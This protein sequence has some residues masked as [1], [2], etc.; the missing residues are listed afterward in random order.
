[1]ISDVI[2]VDTLR[3]QGMARKCEKHQ[4]YADSVGRATGTQQTS[5]SS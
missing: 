4:Q 5:S 3:V 1:M 2:R